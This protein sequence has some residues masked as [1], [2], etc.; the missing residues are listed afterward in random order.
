MSYQTVLRDGM[1]ADGSG[2]EPVPADVAIRDGRVAA[3]TA[4][5]EIDDANTE[6][7]IDATGRFLLPGFVDAH[8]HAEGVLDRPETQLAMLRQGVTTV[9]LGQ[10]GL[11]FAPASAACVSAISRY[12]AAVNGTV[13]A[14]WA[15]GVTV[16]GLLG[17][18]DRTTPLNVGYLVPLGTVRH[19]VLGPERRPA[20]DD[21]PM[22]VQ[23]VRRGLEEGALGVST[24]LEYVPGGFADVDEL[25]ALTEPA[26]AVGAPYVTHLR[27]YAEGRAPGMPEALEITRRAGAGLH[28]SHYR[29]WAE[30]LLAHLDGA[31]VTFDSYPHLYGN[32][33]LAMKALPPDVQDGG[34]QATLARLNDPAVRRRLVDEWFPTIRPELAETTIGYVASEE[35]RWM[36]G[37]T[38]VAA[39]ERAG[40]PYHQ[41]VL[42]LLLATDLVVNCVIPPAGDPNVRLPG[43]DQV[44]ELARDSR[45]MA[46][47]DGIYLGDHPHPRGWSA[48]AR[49]LGRFTRELGDW[50][51]GEAARHL[52]SL[53]AERFG[54]AGR[55]RLRA[56]AIADIAVVDPARVTAH[57]DYDQ[58]RLLAEGVDDVLVAGVP[59]LRDGELTGATPGRALRRGEETL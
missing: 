25:V 59:V 32:T 33:I 28:V 10:D 35:H 50:R 12:F 26:A 31:D 54:L 6:T 14:A 41:L 15:D 18:L 27:S 43:E 21:L 38:I 55:G 22:M 17:S 48:F 58:P 44:R 24:G 2:A 45:Q 3:I 47:S 40:V 53:A 9:L 7:V 30:P 39:A 20:R 56:G 46:C 57:A 29:G 13:P 23:S 1:V 51:W 52:A 36:S 19:D 5:G 16:D 11:S 34:T 8:V 4:P 49:F 42:D 37:L